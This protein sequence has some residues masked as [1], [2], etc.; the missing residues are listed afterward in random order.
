MNYIPYDINVEIVDLNFGIFRPRV[1]FLT[2]RWQLFSRSFLY[3]RLMFFSDFLNQCF[4]FTTI[5]SCSFGHLTYRECQFLLPYLFVAS[6]NDLANKFTGFN[7][8]NFV[9]LS[10]PLSETAITYLNTV[11][12]NT[13]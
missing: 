5:F 1:S 2:G 13:L 12:Y 11:N 4:A 9:S 3:S 6:L 7:V 8:D 10:C